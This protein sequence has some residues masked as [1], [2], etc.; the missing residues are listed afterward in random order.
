MNKVIIKN[1]EDLYTSS[2]YPNCPRKTL[3][4]NT[5]SDGFSKKPKMPYIGREYGNNSSVPKLLF[6][7]LDSG[8]EYDN[9]HTVE[10]IRTEVENN[11]PRR[12]GQDKGKHWYQ[13]FDIAGELLKSYFVNIPENEIEFTDQY[14]AHTNS[15]K[16]TQSKKS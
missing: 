7:S 16:C 14:I 13:T 1:I 12:T 15:S 10:E 4:N 11:P 9:L 6:V 3:C 5:N 2:I 8:D